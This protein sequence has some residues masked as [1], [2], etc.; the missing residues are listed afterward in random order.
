MY[1]KSFFPRIV[2]FFWFFFS[3]LFGFGRLLDVADNNAPIHTRRTPV[4]S[5]VHFPIKTGFTCRSL[6]NHRP[7][8]APPAPDPTRRSMRA[9]FLGGNDL[10]WYMLGL[11]NASGMFDIAGRWAV[12][13]RSDADTHFSLHALLLIRVDLINKGAGAYTWFIHHR[14]SDVGGERPVTDE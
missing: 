8:P 1:D 2:F 10:P 9:Y 3:F 7:P 13:R 6:F 4:T 14:Q 12:P 5:Y 11:S